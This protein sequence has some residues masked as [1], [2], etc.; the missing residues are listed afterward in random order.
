MDKLSLRGDLETERHSF[1]YFEGS[2]CKGNA[3]IEEALRDSTG[4]ILRPDACS[5]VWSISGFSSSSSSLSGCSSASRSGYVRAFSIR[6]WKKKHIKIPYAHG[7]TVKVYFSFRDMENKRANCL[8]IK[9]YPFL[10][11]EATPISFKMDA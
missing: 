7:T 5:E 2:K 4:E 1:G 10:F 8:K 6:Q 11:N 3:C 9:T